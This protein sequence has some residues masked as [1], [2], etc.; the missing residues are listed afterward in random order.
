MENMNHQNIS[1]ALGVTPKQISQVLTLTAEG[2]TIP[3]IAR[4]RKEATGNLDEVVIKAIIDMDKSLTQLRERKDT[5]LAKI[6]GQGKLTAALKEAIEAADKLADLEELYLP[7]KEKRR[8]KAT[9]AR[10]AGL[11]G[12][13]RLILQNAQDLETKAE[14][15]ITEGFFGSTGSPCWSC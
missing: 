10:E 4:Y 12:L 15:F 9:I 7:Y 2:N 13:A 6:E 3:F 14:A 8:T 11:S 5:I 1:E